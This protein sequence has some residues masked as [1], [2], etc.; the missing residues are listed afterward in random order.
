MA[1]L[2]EDLQ[3]VGNNASTSESAFNSRISQL[4]HDGRNSLAELINIKE[5]NLVQQ[6]QVKFVETLSARVSTIDEDRRKSEEFMIAKNEELIAQNTMAIEAIERNHGKL[7]SKLETEMLQGF[8]SHSK[9]EN[10]FVNLLK[11]LQERHN[12]TAEVLNSRDEKMN[13]FVMEQ[14]NDNRSY[15]SKNLD[16]LYKKLDDFSEKQNLDNENLRVQ[17]ET[18]N[19]DL[20]GKL[21]DK[22]DKG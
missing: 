9:A 6:E 1:V 5:A 14:I 8:E 16:E 7:L 3:R 17:I 15:V 4:E 12:E 10:N 18:K 22:V 11:E 20:L 21:H 2:K 19:T 13:I